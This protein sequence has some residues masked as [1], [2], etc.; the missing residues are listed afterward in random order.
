MVEK[1]TTKKCKKCG[2][3][4]NLY[5]RNVHKKPVTYNIC[6]KCYG[7]IISKANKQS[8]KKD[9]TRAKRQSKAIKQTFSQPEIKTKLSNALYKAYAKNPERK[10]KLSNSL[11]LNYQKHPE[12]KTKISNGM[13]QAYINNPNLHK[14]IS[15]AMTKMHSIPEN[16]IKYSEAQLKSYKTN[17]ERII[18]SSKSHI[19]YYTNS[20]ARDKTSKAMKKR[21]YEHPEDKI[22]QSINSKKGLLKY[23]DENPEAKQL[24]SINMKKYIKTHPEFKTQLL[25]NLWSGNKCKNTKPELEMKN[26]LNQLN[27]KYNTQ[28]TFKFEDYWCF[29]DFYLPKYNLVIEVDGKYYHN[30]EEFIKTRKRNVRDIKKNKLY[31]SLNLNLLRYW[32]N[33]FDLNVVKN[34]LKK[35]KEGSITTNF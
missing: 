1:S 23:Y 31:K 13:K 27:I 8:Y 18:K 5:I 34:D 16:K 11:K 2:T 19:K 24:Q 30:Y 17:P 22:R 9:P 35:I 25:K 20:E 26:I 10:L 33:E 29:A 15:K 6:R 4:K 3:T 12:I 7:E 32:E 14:K 28:Q 21:Y